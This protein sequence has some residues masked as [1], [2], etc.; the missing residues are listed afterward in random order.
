MLSMDEM[1]IAVGVLWGGAYLLIIRRGHLDRTYGVPLAAICAN[2]AWELLH[3]TGLAA[4]S[5]VGNLVPAIWLAL[6]LVIAGQ[7]LRRADS[8]H[9]RLTVRSRALLLAAGVALAAGILY[10]ADRT[11]FTLVVSAF[12]QNALMSV[13]FL[14]MA[15]RRRDGRGQSIYIGLLKLAGTALPAL[16]ALPALLQRAPAT[17]AVYIGIVLADILYVVLLWRQ[18]ARTGRRPL[19]RL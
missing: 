12:G 16:N 1:A 7:F 15:V 14:V 5:P 2:L 9:P 18:L 6:D 11:G 8:E 19:A 3:A 4:K 10:G 13:L 17:S